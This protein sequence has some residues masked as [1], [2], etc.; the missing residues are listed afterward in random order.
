M[1]IR[2]LGRVCF[3]LVLAGAAAILVVSA[4]DL[5]SLLSVHLGLNGLALDFFTHDL[6]RRIMVILVI[7]LPF[8]L[9][10]AIAILPRLTPRLTKIPN[11]SYWLSP[12]RR[13]ESLA[14]L[15]RQGVVLGAIVI[16]F[17]CAFHWLLV[18]ANFAVPGR[19]VRAP[20]AVLLVFLLAALLVWTLS[21]QRRFRRLV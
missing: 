5:T 12:E 15:E 10:A 21:I 20:F 2:T 13:A 4:P 18:D 3:L 7:G 9:F 11:S 6:Y 8:L 16:G 17:L 19:L 1:T 14:Y